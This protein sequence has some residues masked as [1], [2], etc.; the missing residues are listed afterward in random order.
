MYAESNFPLV[1]L[2]ALSL[3]QL[4]ATIKQLT[5]L[6]PVK[7]LPNVQT[8]GFTYVA[9]IK[10]LNDAV[11]AKAAKTLMWP[12][13]DTILGVNLEPTKYPTKYPDI[14]IPVDKELKFSI[15]DLTPIRLP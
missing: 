8:I 1:L 4:S 3:S 10:I 11:E 2:F 12:T 13:L 15:T 7:N 9:I 5:K 6:K 14:I